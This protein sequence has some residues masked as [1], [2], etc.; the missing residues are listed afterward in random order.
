MVIVSRA[1]S[2][3]HKKLIFPKNVNNMLLLK[4]IKIPLL[5]IQFQ[6][7]LIYIFCALRANCGTVVFDHFVH[8]F[9]KVYDKALFHSIS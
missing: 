5:L 2:R 4:Y 6:K 1:E 9:L 8:I 3:V 7:T